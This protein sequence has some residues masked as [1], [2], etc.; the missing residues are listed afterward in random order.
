MEFAPILKVLSAM[1]SHA[2]SMATC[3][4]S[5]E[6]AQ[7]VQGLSLVPL[8]SWGIVLWRDSLAP[9]EQLPKQV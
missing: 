8:S 4:L 9:G 5:T 3:L 6:G 7:L 2:V 1:H